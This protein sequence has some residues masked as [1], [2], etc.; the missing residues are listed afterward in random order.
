MTTRPIDCAPSN[1][2]LFSSDLN[3]GSVAVAPLEFDPN[4]P[5]QPRL[6]LDLTVHPRGTVVGKTG[7][8]TVLKETRSAVG[9]GHSPVAT[10]AA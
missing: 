6:A 8:V 2:S 10:C 1:C 9:C 4:V 5:P 3:L 7:E